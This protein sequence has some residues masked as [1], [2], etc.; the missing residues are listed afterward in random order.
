[1]RYCYRSE[2]E[3]ILY[4][5][6]YKIYHYRSSYIKFISKNDEHGKYHFIQALKIGVG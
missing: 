6:I 4:D 1:M 2:K 3:K 5:L